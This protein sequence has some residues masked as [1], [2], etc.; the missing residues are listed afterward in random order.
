M[1]NSWKELTIGEY[2]K[3]QGILSGDD[4]DG[5]KAVKLISILSGDSIESIMSLSTDEVLELSKGFE[6]LSVPP[7]VSERKRIEYGGYKFKVVTELC[8]GQLLDIE[9]HPGMSNVDMAGV[10]LVPV[11]H[12]YRDGYDIDFAGI[13]YLDWCGYVKSFVSTSRSCIKRILRSTRMWM[14][15]GGVKKSEA[16]SI[17][18]VTEHLLE[19][20]EHL[21]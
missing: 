9:S 21:F 13:S 11:G 8:Y 17:I 20:M 14:R 10:L 15:L 3:I 4:V 18:T 16:L 6:F 1:K 12:M 7:E 19:S 2:D 5:M